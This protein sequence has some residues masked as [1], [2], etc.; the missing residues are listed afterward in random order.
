MLYPDRKRFVSL[1]YM[2]N[3]VGNLWYFSVD[4][5]KLHSLYVMLQ[6]GDIGMSSCFLETE[7]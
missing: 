1:G 6:Q 7:F 5:L 2:E 3:F 4:A